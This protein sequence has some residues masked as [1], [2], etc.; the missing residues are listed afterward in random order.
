MGREKGRG[1][2]KMEREG[3]EKGREAGTRREGALI[4]MK[5]PNRNPKYATVCS[6]TTR[7]M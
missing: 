4:E 5:A 6:G 3:G 2:K 7:D 1:G